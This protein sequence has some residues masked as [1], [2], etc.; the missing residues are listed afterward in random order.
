[1]VD[2]AVKKACTLCG[3]F[4]FQRPDVKEHM[5][6]KEDSGPVFGPGHEGWYLLIHQ[7]GYVK[8]ANGKNA[9]M[10][11]QRAGW[12]LGELDEIRVIKCPACAQLLDMKYA[13]TPVAMTAT[14]KVKKFTEH[15]ME[16]TIKKKGKKLKHTYVEKEC[17]E[18]P[19]TIPQ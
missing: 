12:A 18:A 11:A 15:L 2:T 16:P 7:D 5:G 3:P 1:V 10:A 19:S 6:H 17:Y 14:P 8:E 4:P 9:F 13:G